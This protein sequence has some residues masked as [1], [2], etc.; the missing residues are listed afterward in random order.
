MRSDDVICCLITSNPEDRL[1][2]I[3]I[4]NKDM[5]KGQLEFESKVKL[6][7][8]FTIHKKMIFKTIGKL[9]VAKS[10]LVVSELNQI[11]NIE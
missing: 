10:K 5:E 4:Y 11:I 2:A 3:G 8:I 1:H 6:H 7:R 9:N